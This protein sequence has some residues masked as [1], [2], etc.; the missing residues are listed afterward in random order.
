MIIEKKGKKERILRAK[1]DK[2]KRES[3]LG[4]KRKK[5]PWEVKDRYISKK[6]MKERKETVKEEKK[7]GHM[8]WIK[9]DRK[10]WI[11]K[12]KTYREREKEKMKI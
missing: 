4:N 5:D 2:K 12:Q 7:T 11:N 6:E 8:E 3:I 10:E 1:K 9:K